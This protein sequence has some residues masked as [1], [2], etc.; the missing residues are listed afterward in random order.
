MLVGGGHVGAEPGIDPKRPA[1]DAAY[2]H[3]REDSCGI[4]IVDYSAVR[5]TS[6]TMTNA[7]FINFMNTPSQGDLPPRDPWVKVRWINIG[8]MDWEVI[9]AVSLKYSTFLSF[10]VGVFA[11][12]PRL[13]RS[14]PLGA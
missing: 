13:V 10:F 9:K 8:G 1:V 4:E 14:A 12:S 2:C 5:S 11:N 6:R 7:E 3:I